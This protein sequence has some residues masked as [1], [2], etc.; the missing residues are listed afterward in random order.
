M[1]V[2]FANLDKDVKRR[3]IKA[4]RTVRKK[5]LALK[6][7]R[8]EEDEALNKFLTPITNP[9]N[10]LVEATT[11]NTK[12]KQGNKRTIKTEKVSEIKPQVDFLKDDEKLGDVTDDDDEEVFA[13][14]NQ[15]LENKSV[16]DLENKSVQDIRKDFESS[17][18]DNVVFEQFL[19]TYPEISH[20]YV[21]Q[22]WFQ[23]PDLDSKLLYDPELEKW[24]LGSET[25]DFLKNGD[26]QVGSIKYAGTKGLYDLLFLKNPKYHTLKDGQE[27]KD[28]LERSGVYHSDSGRLKGN[29]S[30]KYKNIVR[31]LLSSTSSSSKLAP[32]AKRVKNTTIPSPVGS[33]S[34]TRTRSTAKSG[35]ALMEYNEKPKEYVYYDDVNELV[36]R[37]RKLEASQQVGNNNN[38]NEIMNILKELEQLGVIEFFK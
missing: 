8:S 2:Q 38:S 11:T 17:L 3:I 16:Q 27:F 13:E 22:Y 28:I 18:R 15:T 9:L 20:E 37:M 6:L 26:I 5:Y 4:A 1:S 29:R 36:D 30:D 32:P 10:K 31:P 33:S 35:S 21:K 25:V 24:S 14:A 7:E 23:S 12:S 34:I 19:E